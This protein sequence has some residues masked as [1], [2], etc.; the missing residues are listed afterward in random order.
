MREEEI[1]AADQARRAAQR[2]SIKGDVQQKVRAGIVHRADQGRLVDSGDTEA[3]ADKLTR[4]AVSEVETTEAELERGKV[5]A[6]AS[7]VADYLFCLAYGLIGLEIALDAVGAR[8]SAGF[9]QFIDAITTPLLAP[10]RRLTPNP[11][12]GPFRFM[13]SYI[14]AL[15]VYML[16]H[17][18][19][20]GF[21]R[22]FVHKK[23]VV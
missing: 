12:V 18:A 1:L 2:E 13:L 5:A 3:L 20:N 11:G 17:M 16:L 15:T 8:P 7:Q 21:L 9:K 23:T 22:L 19:V 14:I 4:K 10:F 6:R